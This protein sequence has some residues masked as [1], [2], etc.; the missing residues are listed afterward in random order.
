MSIITNTVGWVVGDLVGTTIL[1]RCQ[2]GTL[3]YDECNVSNGFGYD[4]ASGYAKHYASIVR[5]ISL[6]TTGPLST[7]ASQ[8]I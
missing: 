3:V 7:N 5:I 4:K 8:Y 6:A 1:Q 2:K